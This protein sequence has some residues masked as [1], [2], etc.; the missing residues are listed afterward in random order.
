MKCEESERRRGLKLDSCFFGTPTKA[1][2]QW[3][4][5]KSCVIF[6]HLDQKNDFLY[7]NLGILWERILIINVDSTESNLIMPEEKF[8][9]AW[10]DKDYEWPRINSLNRRS[11][12]I[13]SLFSMSL[14]FLKF[15]CKKS[16][17]IVIILKLFQL[18]TFIS[19][20]VNGN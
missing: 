18:F 9:S 3:K 2:V 10:L 7:W 4:S 16:F 5:V 20:S 12:N 14:C 15:L 8:M 11:F 13:S 19:L 6:Y 17:I 1:M